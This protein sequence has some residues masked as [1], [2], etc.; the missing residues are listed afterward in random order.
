MAKIPHEALHHI[1]R[2]QPELFTRTMRRVL[3]KDY[4]DIVEVAELNCD[5]TEIQAIDRQADTLLL[6]RTSEG[7]EILLIEPQT[8]IA[9]E[10]IRCWAWYV[11]YLENKYQLP[12]TLLIVTPTVATAKWARGSMELGP[13]GRPTLRLLPHVLGPDNVELITDVEQAEEDVIFAVFSTLTH[14]LDADVEK[15]LRPLAEA[16]KSLELETAAYWAEYVEGGLDGCARQLWK[17]IIVDMKYVSEQRRL[18]IDQ[19][20]VEGRVEGRFELAVEMLVFMLQSSGLKPTTT[21]L[22]RITSTKDVEKLK[23]WTARA[24][25]AERVADIFED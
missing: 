20:R 18:G 15:A 11:A 24:V 9:K 3:G 7:D 2:K 5:L 1:F 14:R 4:P 17:D 13:S 10:K 25:T 21:E 12:V 23:R 16:L 8:K 19:G 6:A 22:V